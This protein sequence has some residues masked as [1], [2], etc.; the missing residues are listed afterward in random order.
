MDRKNKLTYSDEE[1]GELLR[2]P[3]RNNDPLRNISKEDRIMYTSQ[4]WFNW[5]DYEFD[6]GTA[7]TPNSTGALEKNDWY[8]LIFLVVIIFSALILMILLY[9]FG[10][11]QSGLPSGVI[12]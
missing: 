2:N 1:I 4:G 9:H 8:F 6:H 5:M 10:Y 11:T 3:T 7:N 12:P